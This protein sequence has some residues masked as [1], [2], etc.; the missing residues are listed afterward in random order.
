M[1]WTRLL[2]GKEYN[3]VAMLE[4]VITRILIG[5]SQLIKQP[6]AEEKEG[7]K[8]KKEE[9]LIPLKVPKFL[10]MAARFEEEREL[11]KDER[12]ITEGS[13]LQE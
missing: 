4:R 9:Y 7:V 6:K 13:L 3:R 11:I 10:E 8:E 2:N 1:E 5:E 12:L